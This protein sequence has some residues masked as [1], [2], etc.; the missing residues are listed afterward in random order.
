MTKLVSIFL[1]TLFLNQI[2]FNMWI[3]IDFYINQEYLSK[4]KCVNRF[5]VKSSCQAK[6]VLV[7]SLS[8]Y[9]KDTSPISAKKILNL[10]KIKIFKIKN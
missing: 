5:T 10:K 1:C 4:T 6:C 2:T 9:Q 8:N 7:S 3:L